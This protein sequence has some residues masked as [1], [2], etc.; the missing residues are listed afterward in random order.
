MY[1]SI[2]ESWN[3]VIIVLLVCLFG[4]LV[5]C[6]FVCLFGLSQCQ[7]PAHATLGLT[8]A[9][10]TKR[11]RREE[12]LNTGIRFIQECP[13]C[14][15]PWNLPIDCLHVTCTGIEG[16]CNRS[17]CFPCAASYT[18]TVHHGN[19]YHRPQCS[20]YSIQ[21][22]C[23]P[24]CLKDDPLALCV[25]TQ[26]WPGPCDDCRDAETINSCTHSP[27][28]PCRPCMQSGR[29]CSHWCDECYRKKSVCL[30]PGNPEDATGPNGLQF[31]VK[32]AIISGI[33]DVDL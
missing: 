23:E 24:L 7:Q 5:G 27:W 19:W 1:A 3:V 29:P 10:N 21:C 9:Q 26:Y 2:K 25:K 6:L 4:W 11:I 17:F 32:L 14:E 30:P 16:C 22:D 8:C 31:Q 28:K 13:F 15:I 33:I 18:P 12:I 20:F